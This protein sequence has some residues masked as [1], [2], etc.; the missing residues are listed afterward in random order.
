MNSRPANYLR[1]GKAVNSEMERI[2]LDRAEYDRMLLEARTQCPK[3]ACGLLA[4]TISEDGE[5]IVSKVYLLTNIDQAEEHFSLDPK[6]Q[7]DAI[8][9]MRKLGLRPLGNWHSHPKTPSRPSEEDKRLAYDR[10]AVYMILSFAEAE[11]VLNAFHI[12]N[13]EARKEFLGIVEGEQIA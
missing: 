12:E 5:K 8:R 11:P 7:L 13:G 6:E 1:E 10:Q 9:N 2:W 3:E 4:G